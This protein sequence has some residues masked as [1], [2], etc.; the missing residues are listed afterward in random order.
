MELMPAIDLR[1]G[2]VVRLRQGEDTRRTDY[3]LAP[4][5]VLERY[6]ER[7]IERVHVVD[8]DAAFGEAPQRRLVA[9]LARQSGAPRLE[10]GGGLRDREAVE[11]AFDAGVERVVVG[12]MIVQDFPLLRELA[13]LWSGRVV[14]A[15]DV[16]RGE[17]RYGGWSV[18]ARRTL[19][20]ICGDLRGLSLGAVLVTDIERD[21][22]LKGPNLTLTRQVA[23][24]VGVPG[25][26]SGGVRSLDDLARAREAPEIEAVIVGKAL[27]DGV[28]DLDAALAVCRGGEAA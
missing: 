15:L 24:A 16:C 11:W 10:L 20:D 14:A 28:L 12:S 19:D 17:L 7:G 26:L 6:G 4:A 5:S 3:G 25:I 9:R 8:L 18:R 22:T 27:Y 2:R 13:E 21:G 23:G 1:D